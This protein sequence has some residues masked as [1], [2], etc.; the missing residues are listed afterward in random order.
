LDDETKSVDG[1]SGIVPS[2]PVVLDAILVR[3]GLSD[4]WLRVNELQSG[5]TVIVDELN[6][7]IRSDGQRFDV[8]NWRT[9]TIR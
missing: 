3:R 9:H 7:L 1:S 5:D 4:L 8:S 6:K 2:A